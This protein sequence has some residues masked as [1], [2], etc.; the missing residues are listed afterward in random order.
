MIFPLDNN[1]PS[2]SEMILRANI[3]YYGHHLAID[4]SFAL[5]TIPS[6]TDI[7]PHTLYQIKYYRILIFP[8]SL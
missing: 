6:V 4:S 3:L 7:A 5:E 1:S 8:I 2:I